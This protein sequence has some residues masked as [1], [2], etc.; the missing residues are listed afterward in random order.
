MANETVETAGSGATKRAL[1]I[2]AA[3]VAVGL[4]IAFHTALKGWLCESAW[5]HTSLVDGPALL[6]AIIAWRELGHSEEANEHRRQMSED[7][8]GTKIELGKQTEE[9]KKANDLRRENN[10]LG[11]KNAELNEKL[12]SIQQQIA[13]NLKPTPTKAERNASAL[14]KYMRKMASVSKQET[15][16]LAVA[17]ELVELKDDILT[18]FSPASQNGTSA[19]YRKVDC[20]DLTI[21]EHPHGGCAVRINVVKYQGQAVDL[22][23]VTG[24]RT[25]L[26]LLRPFRRHQ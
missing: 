24:G 15:S 19:I 17:Y 7:L 3:I 16:N 11:R 5:F 10:D 23:Q 6:L 25:A 2:A 12:G 18:L 8:S 26:E 4:S 9:A 20:G 13:D 1:I 22:G 14:G 21:D